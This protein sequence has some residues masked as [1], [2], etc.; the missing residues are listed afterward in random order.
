[1]DMFGEWF[2]G[3]GGAPGVPLHVLFEVLDDLGSLP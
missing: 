2:K 1:M 3:T